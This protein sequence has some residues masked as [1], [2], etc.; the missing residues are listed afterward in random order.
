M[1]RWSS[2]LGAEEGVAEMTRT[3]S[4]LKREQDKKNGS[5]GMGGDGFD[6]DLILPLS[7]GCL[8]TVSA[9]FSSLWISVK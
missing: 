5:T 2:R 3:E 4:Q 7:F 1:R 6:L 8:K 9:R